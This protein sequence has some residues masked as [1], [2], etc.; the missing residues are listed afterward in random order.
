MPTYSDDPSPGYLGTSPVDPDDL[1]VI[2]DMHG[3]PELAQTPNTRWTVGQLMYAY[4]H[5]HPNQW[6][7]GIR[8]FLLQLAVQLGNMPAIRNVLGYHTMVAL[9]PGNHR[10]LAH[11]YRMFFDMAVCM[12]SIRRLFARIVSLGGYPSAS[13]HMAHYPY[14]MDN[15]TM[16]LVAA[17]FVQH[18]I[19]P[20]MQDVAILESFTRVHRNMAVH[21]TNLANM[22]WPDAL[23]N[24]GA[25]QALAE[26]D[27]PCW[28]DL[29]HALCADGTTIAVVDASASGHG[30]LAASMH[31]PMP[32]EVEPPP[33]PAGGTPLPLPP[34]ESGS[35]SSS[36]HVGSAPP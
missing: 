10:R 12:F 17:W 28:A 22:E 7:M 31:A 25:V 27:V 3:Y 29:R 13:L 19:V 35:G 21:I 33:T 23:Q 34:P 24:I 30:R 8:G 5:R 26:A 15:I 1:I 18:G 9:S 32:M 16:A 2:L 11:Q 36:E 4:V 14:L 20:G 6:G